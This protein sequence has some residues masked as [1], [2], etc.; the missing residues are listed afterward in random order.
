MGVAGPNRIAVEEKKGKKRVTPE[1]EVG[2]VELGEFTRLMDD[3]CVSRARVTH[4]T[5]FP[6]VV[7]AG[8]EIDST[9]S[10]LTGRQCAEAIESSLITERPPRRALTEHREGFKGSSGVLFNFHRA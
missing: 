1:V 4:V 3:T 9:Q 10:V 8:I 2:V 6:A 7:G 5:S